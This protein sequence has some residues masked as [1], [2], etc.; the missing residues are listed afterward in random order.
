MISGFDHAPVI[1][2]DLDAAVAKFAALFGRSP[3]W[4]GRVPGARH[5][6]FQLANF[7]IDL[8][9][10]DG[11]GAAGDAARARLQ[12]RGQ[13]PAAIGFATPA[14]A[15]AVRMLNRRGVVTAQPEEERSKGDE[16]GERTW[17]IAM[18]RASS[19]RGL[20]LFLVE[21]DEQAAPWPISPASGDETA[22]VA[23]VDHVVVRTANPEASVALYG[24]KLDLDLRLDRSNPD[25]GSRLL[26]FR[27]GDAIVEVGASLGA[28]VSDE[29]DRLGGFAWRVPE[30]EAAHARMAAAGLDVSE[31]RKGRK[32]GTSVFTVRDAVGG[33]NL[34][35][36][37]AGAG[38][39]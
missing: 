5:A 18:T 13:G 2:H 24:A 39:D 1:V 16:G 6:W 9:A 27:C 11:E 36:S 3:N 33:P 28:P 20:Q 29:R 31:L 37:A 15:E 19:T 26:F 38:D 34:I 10:P 35:I 22:A 32:V 7:A 21:R 8:I 23:A 30:P 25:W 17:R 12:A 14:L 4:R